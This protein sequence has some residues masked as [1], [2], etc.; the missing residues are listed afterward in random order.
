MRTKVRAV[1]KKQPV[2]VA[3]EHEDGRRL[4]ADRNREAVVSAVLEIVRKQG[5]GP[6]PGAG[7]VA[8]RAK[9]SER[10]VFRHFADLDSL[11]LT[12]ASQQRPIHTTYLT[13]RPDAKKLDERI[14]ALVKLRSKLYEEIAPVRRLAVHVAANHPALA[15]QLA[16]SAKAARDQAAAVF[17]PELA[18]AGRDKS[19]VLD[20]VDLILSWAAWDGLRTGQ[21]ASADRARKLLSEMLTSTLGPFAGRSR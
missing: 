12:A 17:A 16:E 4:R 14:A 3:E 2:R 11:F 1:A 20:R 21:K 5:G 19:S 7:M 6:V 15:T 9:V 8:Q 10:T 13:P 18:K